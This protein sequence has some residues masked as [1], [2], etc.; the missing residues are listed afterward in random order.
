MEPI[1]MQSADAAIETIAI[2]LTLS[3]R[4]PLTVLLFA[5]RLHRSRDVDHRQDGENVG[6]NHSNEQSQGVEQINKAVTEMEKVIQQN[7]ANAEEGASASQELNAQSRQMKNIVAD[8][9]SLVGGKNGASA[10]GMQLSKENTRLASEV[11]FHHDQAR[12]HTM[13]T[14]SDPMAAELHQPKL[15]PEQLIPLD[16]KEF[17]D[18]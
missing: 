5:P 6:L 7:A 11:L 17:Q 12:Y 15:T 18:F 14:G 4:S 9:V 2:T 8:M 1:A 10:N 13:T 16:D 3:I